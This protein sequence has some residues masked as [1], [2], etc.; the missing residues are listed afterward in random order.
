MHSVSQNWLMGSDIYW[1]AQTFLH[2]MSHHLTSTLRKHLAP[3]QHINKK[4]FSSL[5]GS[6]YIC[7]T[8]HGRNI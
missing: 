8:S 3:A 4:A 2:S 1:L 6:Y 7:Y 5:Y